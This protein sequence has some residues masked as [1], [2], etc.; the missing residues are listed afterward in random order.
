HRKFGYIGV[1]GLKCLLAEGLVD[2]FTVN[3]HSPS[4]DCEA[5][6]QVKQEHSSYLKHV[7]TQSEHPGELTH[8]DVW[9]PAQVTGM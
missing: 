7:S 9:G 5:C 2:G 6:I 3:E 8:T 4:F 1:K